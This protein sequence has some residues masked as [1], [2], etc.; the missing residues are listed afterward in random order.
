MNIVV[1]IKQVPDSA[2][3][4]RAED[5]KAT[6][7][8]APLVMNPWDEYAVETALLQSEAH[9]GQVTVISV[10]GEGAQE[11]IK[12]ALAMGCSQAY[13]VSDPALEAADSQVIAHVLAGAI[14]KVG[15]VDLAFFGKQA[16]DAD[17]GVTAPQT[18]RIL[19]WPVL[20]LVSTIQEVD[21]GSGS[22]KVERSV[23]EGR[24][25][26]ESKL[27]AVLTV[28]KDIAEPRYPSF[29][30]IRKAAKAE[31]PVWTLGDLDIE[32]P[33]SVVRW[34]ELINPETREIATEILT[35]GNPEE[36]AQTLVDKI[37]GEKVL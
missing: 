28:S 15:D 21:P 25:V 9:G 4:V 30:G 36:I 16:I 14:K 20:S 12:S 1:C 24:Q 34:P 8:D 18:A 23:E 27:P 29:M 10:G 26:V 19:G 11:A 37:L 17:M 31:I 22:I 2:A 5:G 33:G 3:T 13:R 32:V 6:W 7:G 35:G